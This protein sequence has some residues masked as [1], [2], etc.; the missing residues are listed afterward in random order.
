MAVV[1]Y[2]GI[3]ESGEITGEFFY[4]FPDVRLGR[5]ASFLVDGIPINR[6]VFVDTVDSSSDP[7]IASLILGLEK[8]TLSPSLTIEQLKLLG[9][10]AVTLIVEDAYKLGYVYSSDPLIIMDYNDQGDFG[11][12]LSMIQELGEVAILGTPLEI[13]TLNDEQTITI[14]SKAE[15]LGLC[16][17]LMTGKRTIQAMGRATKDYIRDVATTQAEILISLKTLASSLGL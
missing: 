4:G 12:I 11:D 1:T 15:L 13:G 3:N 16:T 17:A 10:T 7:Y 9:Y 6:E 5:V 2:Q 14:S 8:E